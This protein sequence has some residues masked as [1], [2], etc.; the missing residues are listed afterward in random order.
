MMRMG[1][2]GSNR[3][4]TQEW[5]LDLTTTVNIYKESLRRTFTNS[6]RLSGHLAPC[7]KINQPAKKKSQL[8]TLEDTE[9]DLLTL[10]Y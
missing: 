10:I 3:C 5:L 8:L 7:R 6:V 9:D 2:K 4:Y 1:V